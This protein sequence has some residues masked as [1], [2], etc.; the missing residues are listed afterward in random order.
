LVPIQS[1]SDLAILQ[2]ENIL[3]FMGQELQHETSLKL[4]HL[5]QADAPGNRDMAMLADLTYKDSRTM[6]I[7]TVISMFYLPVNLAMVCTAAPFLNYNE[8]R[9]GD[10][11]LYNLPPSGDMLRHP[12]NLRLPILVIS[13]STLVWYG[14][15]IEVAE[16][17][18]SRIQIRSEVWIA[19][20]AAVVLAVGTISWP[21][22][23]N[24]REQRKPDKNA[25]EKT[26]ASGS[27]GCA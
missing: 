14:T 21:W 17:S 24:W 1:N 18:G 27:S 4:A 23:W 12:T 5:A 20:L 7:T 8:T 25:A 22:W 11:G 15:A 3:T 6:R 19:S 26:L 16:S 9:P 10:D 13:S 2:Y